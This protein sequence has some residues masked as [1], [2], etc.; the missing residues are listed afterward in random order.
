MFVTGALSTQLDK[1]KRY[2][3]K[4]KT[5]G[6]LNVKPIKWLLA[7]LCTLG[8]L[9]YMRLL[10]RSTSPRALATQEEIVL[11][12]RVTELYETLLHR[13]KLSKNNPEQTTTDNLP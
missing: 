9:I 3:I 12:Y 8:C 2:I 6:K 13:L 5:H 7:V 4:Y 1:A 10:S 11:S